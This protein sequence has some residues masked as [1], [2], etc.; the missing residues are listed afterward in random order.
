[1]VARATVEREAKAAPVWREVR[2]RDP[3]CRT[4]LLRYRESACGAL[5]HV[6]VTVELVCPDRRC[7]RAQTVTL[8]EWG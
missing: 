6:R 1:M 5:A 2:C 7:R 8:P 4:L 3:R